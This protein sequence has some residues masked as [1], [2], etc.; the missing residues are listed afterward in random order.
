MTRV[1]KKLRSFFRSI[2]SLI[3]G[4]GFSSLGKSVF[5]ADLRGAAVGDVA[6][7]ALEH[8]G[9]HAQHAAGHGV[10]GIGVFQVDGL[11]GTGP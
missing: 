4:K 1:S 6:Q 9:I 5:Q 11:A 8:R 2:I 3:Q 10:F 7:V